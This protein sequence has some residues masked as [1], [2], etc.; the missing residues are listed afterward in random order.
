MSSS[1]ESPTLV[2]AD[3]DTDPNNR[4][5]H[6][7]RVGDDHPRHA[8]GSFLTLCGLRIQPRPDAATLPCC[9]MC[10]TAMGRPCR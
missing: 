6:H 5:H 9:P 8:D 1:Q 4:V 7:A 2:D 10:A 3:D